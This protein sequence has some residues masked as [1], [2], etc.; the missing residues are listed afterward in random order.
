MTTKQIE[1]LLKELNISFKF[2]AA[3]ETTDAQYTLLN[4]KAKS[5]A[6]QMLS[7]TKVALFINNGKTG[8]YLKETT[9]ITE[10][11]EQLSNVKFRSELGIKVAL[12]KCSYHYYRNWVKDILTEAG[13]SPSFKKE[14]ESYDGTIFISVSEL[15]DAKKTLNNYV[16]EN[17]NV[18]EMWKF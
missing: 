7:K 5:A 11:K 14:K 1:S 9:L 6:I 15:L 4:T 8:E 17:P 3:T 2:E 18:V 16:K 10:L 13:H 12:A